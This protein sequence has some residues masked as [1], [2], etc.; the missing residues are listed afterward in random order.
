[1]SN[2]VSLQATSSG[3]RLSQYWQFL[4][5]CL[6]SVVL[7]WQPLVSTLRMAWSNGAYTHLLLILPVSLALILSERRPSSR[8]G[9]SAMRSWAG[10]AFLAAALLM[11][12][13][14]SLTA[15]NSSAPHFLSV[16]IFA[17]V[18]WWIGSGIICFGVPAIHSHLFAVG[19]LFLFVPLPDE[20]VNWIVQILQTTS[21]SVAAFL[22]RI[23][24]VPV[25]RDGLILSIPGLDIEVAPECSSI[26]SSTLLVIVTMVLAHLFLR[27][28]WR[29]VLLVLAAIPLSVLKNSVRIFTIAELATRVDPSY[30]TGRLHHQ[31][32]IVFLAASLLPVI[33]MLWWLR[34]NDPP[35]SS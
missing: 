22:F 6:A 5:L 29:K 23:A 4:A 32:G 18:L 35:V 24:Q 26:R 9:L 16:S 12:L 31:G 7:W 1:M 8:L 13:A 15:N 10:W 30:L 14:A 34:K 2:S 11:R 19:F 28:N 20:A 25:A 17:L 33:L 3:T 21:A 27:S